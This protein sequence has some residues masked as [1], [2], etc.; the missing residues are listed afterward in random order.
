M[1]KYIVAAFAVLMCSLAVTPA[2]ASYVVENDMPT[3]IEE[4]TE[5]SPRVEEAVWKYRNN[6]GVRERRLWS[7]TDNCWLTDWMPV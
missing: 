5:A 6:N 2:E 1:N 4:A 3:S 7:I